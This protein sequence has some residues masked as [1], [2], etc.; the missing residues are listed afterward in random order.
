LSAKAV[1]SLG[2]A[3]GLVAESAFGAALVGLGVFF[4][5]M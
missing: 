2:L 3:Q 4:V 5:A 1:G